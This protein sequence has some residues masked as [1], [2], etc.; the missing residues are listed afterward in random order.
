MP[1]TG[2]TVKE[3]KKKNGLGIKNKCQLGSGDM[4]SICRRF[5]IMY[6]LRGKKTLWITR[7]F[8]WDDVDQGLHGILAA[9]PWHLAFV[10]SLCLKTVAGPSWLVGLWDK[11][12]P[13]A[14]ED[15]CVFT[16]LENVTA[17]MRPWIFL[18]SI[19]S[20]CPWVIRDRASCWMNTQS[21][22]QPPVM[23]ISWEVGT[24]CYC[25]NTCILSVLTGKSCQLLRVHN[26]GKFHH[27]ALFLLNL[28]LLIIIGIF[29]KFWDFMCVWIIA[30]YFAA[31]SP[32]CTLHESAQCNHIIY[33]LNEWMNV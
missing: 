29:Y 5:W 30:E 9:A 7:K 15:K 26:Y 12:W 3:K 4:F 25:S 14:C 6:E 27:H 19:L 17:G 16:K 24:I 22:H 10:S 13:E 8:M 32:A 21:E 2:Y 28:I 33:I 11:L 18:I 23:S 31:L 1:G 20:L